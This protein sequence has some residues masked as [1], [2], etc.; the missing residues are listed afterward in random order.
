[1]KPLIIY[2]ASLYFCIVEKLYIF[3]LMIF[4]FFP[5]ALRAV[6]KVPGFTILLKHSHTLDYWTPG[7]SNY[8][9]VI[10]I[11]RGRHSSEGKSPALLVLVLENM[12]IIKHTSLMPTTAINTGGDSHPDPV[13]GAGSRSLCPHQDHARLGIGRHN[14]VLKTMKQMKDHNKAQN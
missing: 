13:P 3:K 5:P 8:H 1:M 7:V 10:N 14:F 9:E 12:Y 4:Q 6:R 2:I 11:K